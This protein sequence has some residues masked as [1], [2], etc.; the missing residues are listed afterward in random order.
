MATRPEAEQAL[1]DAI[2][3]AAE[4]AAR[5]PAHDAGSSALALAQ[6]WQIVHVPER[7]RPSAASSR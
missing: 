2:K 5:N 3:V 1:I 4:Y 7:T 6:A